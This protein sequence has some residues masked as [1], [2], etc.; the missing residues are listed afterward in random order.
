[1]GLLVLAVEDDCRQLQYMHDR[2]RLIA[3]ALRMA[4]PMSSS[5]SVSRRAAS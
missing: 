4:G 2:A 5:V 3:M 1:M